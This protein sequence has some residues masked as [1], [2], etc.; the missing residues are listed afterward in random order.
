MG[1]KR[2]G[3]AYTGRG[4]TIEGAC[5]DLEEQ[6]KKKHIHSNACIKISQPMEKHPLYNKR[7]FRVSKALVQVLLC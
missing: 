5:A 2:S 4:S 6:I 1:N 7:A 3:L